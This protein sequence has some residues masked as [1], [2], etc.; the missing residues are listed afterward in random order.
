MNNIDIQAVNNIR[1]LCLEMIDR[2][3][4]GH[5]G[6][7]MGSAPIMHT[8]FTKF[9][10]ISPKNP[11]WVNRDRFILSSGHV[12]SLL[13]A[14]LHLSGYK[15]S[16]E[17]L[18]SFRKLN[19]I[20]P[21]HPELDVTEGVDASTGPLGQGVA[22][23]VG[24]AIAS[25]YMHN[26][27]PDLINHYTY[28]LCGDGDIQES[29]C[30]EA[31]SLAGTLRL[32][33]LIVLY[34]SNDIQLDGKV[35]NCFDENIKEEMKSIHWNYLKVEDGNDCDAISKAI[36]K[37]QKLEGPTLIEVKTIIGYSTS[38]AN[39][40]KVHGS[41][42]PHDEVV[43]MRKKLGNNEF[44]I[45]KEVYEYYKKTV[46]NRGNREYKKWDKLEKDD[47][48]IKFMNNDHKIDFDKIVKFDS[49]NGNVASRKS[50]SMVLKDISVQ[51]KFFIG[52]SADL[53]SST[54]TVL[55]G[56]MFS[57]DNNGGRNIYFGVRE[58]AMGA[59]TNAI[60]MYG[61]K[62]F[63]STFFSFS[64]YMKPC[65]RLAALSNLPNMFI[66]T[67]DSIAVGEDGPTHE[68]IEQIT[69]CRAIPNV[70]VFRPCDSNEVRETYKLA[71]MSTKTPS[72]IV[73]SRQNLKLVTTET[74][75]EKGAY[76]VS[77]EDKKLDGILIAS[78]SEVALALDVKEVL[79][80]KGLDIRVVSMP[81]ME[82]F[83]KQPLEYKEEIL[84]SNITKK[85]AIEMSDATHYYKYVGTN[86][87]VYGINRFGV[88]GNA[89][90]VIPY[91]GFEKNK[92]AQKFMEIK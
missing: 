4:S 79:K 12:S 2:P 62:S 43:E 85:M 18:K 52:G 54:Q 49:N 76:I 31:M 35:S 84:P 66:Y 29:V 42:I 41:P 20:T 65:I 55:D 89:N 14:M 88:S 80:E 74:K 38:R 63:S 23:G 87:H 9:L 25:S 6:M 5:P 91:L 57:K 19:S 56:D 64:D 1:M 39:T 67:H 72:V 28:V 40:N 37:A 3:Q 46:T 60:V 86:G 22:Y 21:G 10:N 8:L 70:N 78:G 71:Y 59:I 24:T 53:A 61:L 36:K 58:H 50:G 27:Y 44:E 83:D 92:I 32:N 7:A 47:T 11:K 16:I 68:P 81:C 33:K 34:D 26:L 90:E 48:F 73:L 17:D 82:L 77:K 69:M 75:V 13:Y 45:D 15:L 30:K 51:D